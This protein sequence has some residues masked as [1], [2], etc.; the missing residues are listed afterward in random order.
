MSLVVVALVYAGVVLVHE[1]GHV[2]AGL[3]VGV[4]RRAMRIVLRGVPHVAL[5]DG[6]RWL[7]PME[8][9]AYVRVFSRYC[10]TRVGALVYVSGGFAVEAVVVVAAALVAVL[11]GAERLAL[12]I[13]L[14]SLLLSGVYVALDLVASAWK[15]RPLGDAATM[16]TLMPDAGSAILAVSFLLRGGALLAATSANN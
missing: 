1:C 15:R 2:V 13:A 14:V 3:L 10:R 5:T 9:E 4:P 11:L 6:E 16:W 8:R 12:T 7:S